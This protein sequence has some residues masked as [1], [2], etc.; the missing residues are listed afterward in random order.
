LGFF[1][2]GFGVWAAGVVFEHF[3]KN[4][5]IVVGANNLLLWVCGVTLAKVF[6]G[7]VL[8]HRCGGAGAIAAGEVN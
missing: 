7:V 8:R 1:G 4:E 3:L 5:A 6:L 2:F